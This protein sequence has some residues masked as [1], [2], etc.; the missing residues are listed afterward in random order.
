M[1]VLWYGCP[2]LG[3]TTLMTPTLKKKKKRKIE[4]EMMMYLDIEE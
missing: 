4:Y 1:A 2:N 3:H